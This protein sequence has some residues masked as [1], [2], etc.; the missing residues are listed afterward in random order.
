VGFFLREGEG[1]GGEGGGLRQQGVAGPVFPF[2]PSHTSSDF[3]GHWGT[4]LQDALL[5]VEGG[6]RLSTFALV[7]SLFLPLNGRRGS[8]LNSPTGLQSPPTEPPPFPHARGTPPPPCP[9]PQPSCGGT[10]TPPRSSFSTRTGPATGARP[11][12]PPPDGQGVCTSSL[13]PLTVAC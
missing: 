9:P 12:P 7:S 8:F 4:G 5:M 10:G 1:M 13:V 11:P 2:A 6:W 3:S